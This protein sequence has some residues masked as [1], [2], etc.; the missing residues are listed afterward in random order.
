MVLYQCI[1]T[2]TATAFLSAFSVSATKISLNLWNVP[3]KIG[4]SQA[5]EVVM[6]LSL[7]LPATDGRSGRYELSGT[8]LAPAAPRR[9]FNREAYA[10]AHV[11]ADPQAQHDPWLT[12]AID[13]DATLAFRR[14]LWGLG[15]KV[16]EAM[17]TAQR[18]MGLD[19]PNARELIRRSLAEA[20]TIAGADLASGAGT[21]QLAVTPAT[22]LADVMRAY[23]E[24]VG[25]I[26]GEGGRVILMASRALA[27]VARSADDYVAAY[28]AILRQAGRKVILHWL[29][30][31]FDPALAGYWG[32]DDF[33]AQ[34]E[35]VLAIIRAHADRIDGIKISLLS[36]EKE[37]ELR[38]RLPAG[39]KM[40]TGDDFN[41]P[42]LIE[43]DETGHSHLLLGIL[44]PIAPAAA[45]A[46][47]RL[48]AGDGAG[49][50]AALAPT[51]PLSRRIFEA[52]TQ[53]YKAGIVLL[54]W[55]NGF[56]DHFVMIGGLQ[57]ARGIMHYANVFRLADA[58]GLLR[59]PD[60]A[61]G[62]MRALCR[63]HGVE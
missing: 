34:A 21:D 60:L 57:S 5:V 43:G 53:F 46:L 63:L 30:E 54:A 28:D 20:R 25:F 17:D 12:P 45:L 13:W 39:V 41:Y 26:E 11:V 48:A 51:L 62:R 52:P 7:I 47:D 37:I 40:F 44:D 36:Q 50:R 2:D 42:V 9:A 61:V 23:E 24:Q 49:F 1:N 27:A 29:G 14:H 33:G 22:R 32:A 10:A 6:K 59:D 16:A 8:P 58:A 56:Q 4:T 38:R 19:W 35:T 15:L 31:M 55:L 3:I 18:G